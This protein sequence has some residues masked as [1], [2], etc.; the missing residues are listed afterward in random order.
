MHHESMWHRVAAVGH[1]FVQ[2]DGTYPAP[3]CRV[4]IW[5]LNYPEA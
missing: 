5:V 2:H 1:H 4:D 3:R